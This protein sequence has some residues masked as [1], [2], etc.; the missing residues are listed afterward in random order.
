MTQ[1]TSSDDASVPRVITFGGSPLVKWYAYVR[2]GDVYLRRE[3]DGVIASESMIIQALGSAKVADVDFVIDPSDNTVAWIYFID[4]LGN[5]YNMSVTSSPIGE[6]PSLQTFNESGA[7]VYSESFEL[8][9]GAV[10]VEP[11]PTFSDPVVMDEGYELWD[12]TVAVVPNPT[13][14]SAAVMDEQ[15]D[16]DW[17]GI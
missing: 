17:D 16:A 5:V 3:E 1:L 14:P 9:S 11:S 4:T 7:A 10:A 8:W 2:A 13:F 6:M 12:G 15:F